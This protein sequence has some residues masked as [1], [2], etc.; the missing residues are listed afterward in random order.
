MDMFVINIYWLISIRA[1]H[2]AQWYTEMQETW[3]QSLGWEDSLEKGMATHASILAWEILWTEKPGGLRSMGSQTV[4]H[5]WAHTHTHTHTHT[6]QNIDV[7]TVDCRARLSGFKSQ[8]CCSQAGLPWTGY[9]SSLCLSF[10]S[11]NHLPHTLLWG[12]LLL[13]PYNCST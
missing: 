13:I 7:E 10:P 9:L 3:V 8:L 11:M 2:V 1:S 12:S 6:L 4:R 5:N